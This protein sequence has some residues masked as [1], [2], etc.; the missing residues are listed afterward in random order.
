[1]AYK[2]RDTPYFRRYAAEYCHDRYDTHIELDWYYDAFQYFIRNATGQSEI[3]SSFG[4][5]KVPVRFSP[6]SM[7]LFLESTANYL[8]NY[9]NSIWYGISVVGFWVI[10]LLVAFAS[11]WIKVLFPGETKELVGPI[12]NTYRKYIA[13]PA[14]YGKKRN[15]EIGWKIFGSLVPTR[16]EFI[17][18][19]LFYIL[20][21]IIHAIN[22]EALENDPMFDSYYRAQIRYVA[23]RAGII[24]L[25]MLPLIL[26][27]S[28]RNNLL[29]W[30]CGINYST[31][32]C[33]HRHIARVMVMLVVIHSVNFTIYLNDYDE[34]LEESWFYWGIVATT[35]GGSMLWQSIL[36]IRRNWYELFVL[37]HLLMAVFYLVGAWMHVY[38]FGYQI[39]LYPSFAVWG[40]ER[41]VRVCRLFYFGFPKVDVK[42]VGDETIKLIIPRPKTWKPT[43][44]GH[45]FIH[46]LQPTYFWQSHPFTFTNSFKDDDGK[47]VIYVKVKGGATHSLYQMLNK[48][49][50]KMVTMRVGVDGP[51]GESTPAKYSDKAVFI[52]GGNGIPGIYSEVVHIS[53]RFSRE[54]KSILKLIWVIRDYGSIFWFY[55]ELVKLKNVNIETTI[56]VTRPDNKFSTV[57]AFNKTESSQEGSIKSEY[58]ETKSQ[59]SDGE[60]N[61]SQTYNS[62]VAVNKLKSKGELAHI[63]FEEGRPNI[64]EIIR[65]EIK[66][67]PGSV[68]FVACGHPIMV[69]EVRYQTC[70]NIDN[71]EKKRVDFYE[72]LQVWA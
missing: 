36:Y 5:I 13:M 55:D 1:M 44:G 64:E 27:F 58:E 59:T 54:S 31:F 21:I 8:G 67:S 3:T 46:F 43:P 15:Q 71:R 6:H 57:N 50:G 35:I 34:L 37:V 9:D 51:Y 62:E 61:K 52:A 2:N 47:L 38:E 45:A 4:S 19:S 22:M 56:Y 65:Q 33:Y 41:L 32:L 68:S 66:E 30:I 17:T 20:I 12:A 28:G 7:D 53:N 40:F 23:D 70:K 14:L 16:F 48:S 69:D 63:H 72:Q 18:I 49:P 29:Q 11:N 60:E 39:L 42:L 24:S 25:F 26:L 10:V